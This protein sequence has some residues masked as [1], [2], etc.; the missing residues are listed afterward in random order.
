[1]SVQGLKPLLPQVP[2]CYPH[3]DGTANRARVFF[4]TQS[5]FRASMSTSV[6][7]RGQTEACK[8]LLAWAWQRHQEQTGEAVPFTDLGV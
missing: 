4:T 8:K 5:G 1:M 7:K 6:D 2:G 3:W